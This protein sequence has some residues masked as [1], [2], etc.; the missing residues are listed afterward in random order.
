MHADALHPDDGTT[1]MSSSARRKELA[2]IREK[3]DAARRAE[4][5]R[6]AELSMYMRIEE[7][8]SLE[9][10]REILHMLAEKLGMED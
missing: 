8:D 1:A 3:E 2:A 5:H 4:E 10:V 6:R 9:R 7:C